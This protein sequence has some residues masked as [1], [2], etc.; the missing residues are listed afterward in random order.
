M[1]L[2]L[3]AV[4]FRV[5]FG[6]RLLRS[7]YEHSRAV[8]HVAQYQLVD[9]AAK[10]LLDQKLNLSL[11]HY[12]I[13]HHPWIFDVRTRSVSPDGGRS[14]EDNLALVD[15][16]LGEI[17]MRL[18]QE[19]M[20]EDAVVLISSDHW[21]RGQ[22]TD[23]RLDHRVPFFLKLAGQND[24]V[25]IDKPFNTIL[26]RKLLMELLRGN[27]SKPDEVVNWI[28]Q[29]SSLGESPFTQNLP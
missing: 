17:R 12:P 7:R 9:A 13:P 18:E 29:N 22:K 24:A 21:W 2:S 23:T 20:W 16:T 26:T 28:N 6:F 5:P 8:E 10:R 19:S 14:Y 1:G 3:Q 11:L 25:E 27:L 15:K 4:L